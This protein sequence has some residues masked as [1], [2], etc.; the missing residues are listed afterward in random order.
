MTVLDAS[1]LLALLFRERGHEAV[2]KVFD[3]ACVSTVNVAEV[4]TRFARDG[5]DAGAVLDRLA[6]SALSIVP[7]TERH[8]AI[9]AEL[10]PKVRARGLSLGDR[11]C[12]ALARAQAAPAMTADQAWAALDVGV[13]IRLIR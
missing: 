9:A 12:L 5:H 7:F 1:A 4:L 2:E 11:A 3:A 10:A 6:A 8:A 13:Q